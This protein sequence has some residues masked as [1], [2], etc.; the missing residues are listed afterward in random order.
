MGTGSAGKVRGPAPCHVLAGRQRSCGYPLL[1]RF[2]P[3]G[4]VQLPGAEACRKPDQAIF[5]PPVRGL[6]LG[7]R[8]GSR[9]WLLA[10]SSRS[11]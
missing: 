1:S 10:M 2:S 7:K 6:D 9:V 5:P 4:S 8:H 3:P 11:G